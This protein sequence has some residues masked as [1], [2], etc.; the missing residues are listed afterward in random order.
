MISFA[1]VAHPRSNRQAKRANAEMLRGL[2]AR[3]FETL[4]KHDSRWIEELPVVLWSIRTTPNRAT[5]QT[6]F[7]PVYGAEAVIPMELIYESPQVLAYDGIVQDQHRHDDAV[8]HEENHL[9][10]ATRAACY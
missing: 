7:F 8:L 9:R 1:A 4:K 5:G 3:T 6:P 10:A 2:K